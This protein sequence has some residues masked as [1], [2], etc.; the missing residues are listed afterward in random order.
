MPLDPEVWAP[1]LEFTLKTISVLY[2]QRPN[3][4]TK[5]KYYDTIQNLPVF[6][7]QQPIGKEF[8]KLLDKYPVTP[9]LSSRESFM[10]WIHFIINKIRAKMDMEQSDFFDSLE[11][12]YDEYKPKDILNKQKFKKRKQYIMIGTIIFLLAIIVYL[13]KNGNNTVF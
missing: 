13:L 6:F 2:P 5:K 11:K 12:Y 4:V 7:P 3:D 1:H 9:Y 10:K 8:A